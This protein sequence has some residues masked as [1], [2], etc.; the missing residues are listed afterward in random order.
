M[1]HKAFLLLRLTIIILFF[2]T[3]IYAEKLEIIPLKKPT[4]KG[5]VIKKKNSS[6]YIKTKT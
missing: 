6:R 2:N 5:E 3:N 1:P 4:L